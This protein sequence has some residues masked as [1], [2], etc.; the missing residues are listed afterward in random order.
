[1]ADCAREAALSL[2][3]FIR[4]FREVEGTTPHS[5]L[6][7]RRVSEA[8][9]LLDSTGLSVGEIALEVGFGSASALGRA[10][11]Q[12]TGT[13]PTARRAAGM[14][15]IGGAKAAGPDRQ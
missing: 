7:A 15:K 6:N 12:A 8:E 11:K 10:F 4:L 14:S 1:M 2:H 3:H 13:T 5:Y 9:R